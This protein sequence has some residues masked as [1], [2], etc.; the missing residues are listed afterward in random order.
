MTT[1][2]ETNETKEW[3]DR[4]AEI[5]QYK[6]VMDVS[7]EESLTVEKLIHFLQQCDPKAKISID[8]TARGGDGFICER[9]HACHK[10]CDNCETGDEKNDPQLQGWCEPI[11]IAERDLDPDHPEDGGIVELLA[12]SPM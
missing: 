12:E 8:A 1:E 4:L 3:L 5:H 10:F 7:K 6:R 2:N 9:C 11:R